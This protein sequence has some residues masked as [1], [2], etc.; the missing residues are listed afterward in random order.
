MVKL[1]QEIRD[2][3]SSFR[4]YLPLINGLRNADLR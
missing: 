4:H 1:T 2:M 3:Y